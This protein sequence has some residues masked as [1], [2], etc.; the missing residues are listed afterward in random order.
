MRCEIPAVTREVIRSDHSQGIS[1]SFKK[2]DLRPAMVCSD[3]DGLQIDN[4]NAQLAD[5]VTPVLFDD[6][7]QV[8]VKNSPVLET[9][10]K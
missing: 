4:F 10:V 6:V 2:T 3:I 5:D 1:M 8:T 9:G 7:R